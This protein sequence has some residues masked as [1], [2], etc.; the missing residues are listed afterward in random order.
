[1]TAR[2]LNQKEE[3]M[4]KYL[5]I[6]AGGTG[7]AL[8]AYLARGG[9]DVTFIARGAHLRAMKDNGLRVIRTDDEFTLKPVKACTMEEY[10]DHPDVIF[11]CVKGYSLESLYPFLR[12]IAGKDSIVI[13]IL[14][15]YGT[16]AVMQKQ[17]PGI[18][19]TD[20]CIYVASQ[21]RSPGEI[22]MSG[23]ILRV[24]FGV[25][26]SSEFRPALREVEKDLVKCG[27]GGGFSDNIQR[28]TLLKFS[29]VSPQG[30]CGLYFGVS[31]GAMQKEGIYRDFFCELVREIGRIAEKEGIVFTED[32]VKR[33]LHILDSL[34]PDMTTSLQKDVACG[35]AS[36]IDGLI[37]E[38]VRNA[39]RLKVD[40]PA[41]E[42]VA[43][44]LSG[45]AI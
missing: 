8:G 22:L 28:D 20:G 16:G 34:K 23:D 45:A 11:V 32:I 35:K 33:N 36:E 6:G 21:L 9:M 39:R 40:A 19:V 18:L 38:V 15:I 17:L 13:P 12:R 2:G 4:R 29:Y 42:K 3:G 7:G 30:A 37:F 44:K 14:N 1:M 5:V 24:V 41:Y 27:I 26:D 25:R 10:T 43:E 31:A